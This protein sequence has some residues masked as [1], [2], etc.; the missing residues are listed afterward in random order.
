[1]GEFENK[2]VMITGACG[3]LGRVV[4]Q[5]FNAAGATLILSDRDEE[6]MQ[7]L[8]EDLGEQHLGLIVDLGDPESV[9]Q[10]MQKVDDAG[11]VIDVLVHTVGGFAG[12]KPMHEADLS[13]LQKQ[14][15]L[16]TQTV[17]VTCSAVISHMIA[18]DK[19]G[20]LVITLSG[21]ADKGAK[22]LAA[23][24]ASKAAAQSLVESMAAELDSHH[25]R[26]NGVSPSTIDTD[27]NRNAMPN[28]DY[29][30][31]VTPDQI[32]DAMMFLASDRAARINGV[33][34]RVY[35]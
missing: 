12:G 27:A 14:F 26:V 29:S 31:W 3:G 30:K 9:Q 8:L 18:H 25:I 19:A 10:S 17:F 11:L 4:A 13:E 20:N 2:V 16:N 35:G 5:R 1:M 28:A 33:N 23:Y 34:L 21:V 24:S 6:R 15:F 32:T 22:N 7:V